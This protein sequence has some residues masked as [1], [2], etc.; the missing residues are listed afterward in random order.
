MQFPESW[1]RTICNPPLTTQQLADTL[2]MAG[3]EVEE[4]QPVAPPFTGIVVAEIKEAAQHPD[5]DRLN[6]TQVDNKHW[7]ERMQQQCFVL[8][9][10]R[11]KQT[12]TPINSK[13]MRSTIVVSRET[14]LLSQ[15]KKRPVITGRFTIR[16]VIKSGHD[17]QMI[18]PIHQI[19]LTR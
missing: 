3:L 15:K 13:T 19:F 14:R 6:I 18:Q 1:L 17:I 11:S 5:A 10:R 4:L 2:T 12:V 16:Q 9:V 7:F 8:T